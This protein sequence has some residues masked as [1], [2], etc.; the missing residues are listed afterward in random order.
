[1]SQASTVVVRQPAEL[2]VLVVGNSF[3]CRPT[4]KYNQH[5]EPNLK[6]VSSVFPF[7]LLVFVVS[8]DVSVIVQEKMSVGKNSYNR[9]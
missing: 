2:V 9:K 3:T 4:T 8:S 6:E 7:W 5:K 1:M